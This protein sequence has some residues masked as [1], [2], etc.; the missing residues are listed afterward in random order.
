M[1]LFQSCPL[2]TQTVKETGPSCCVT[3]AGS[4]VGPGRKHYSIYNNYLE[5][6][7]LHSFIVVFLLFKL[8]DQ[9]S[10]GHENILSIITGWNT[11]MTVVT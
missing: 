6:S 4:Q 11:H 10:V 2:S 9:Y 1:Y 7:N 5:R 8:F 3:V